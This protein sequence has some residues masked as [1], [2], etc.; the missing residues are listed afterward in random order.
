MADA[1][2]GPHRER[3]FYGRR[4][5]HALS[6]AQEERLERVLPRTRLDL[7]PALARLTDLFRKGTDDVW[8][9]IGFGG[10]EHLAAQ[11]AAHPGIGFIG[12]EPFLNGISQLAGA[13]ESRALDNV[14]MH[15]DEVQPLLEWLPEASIGRVFIL[16]PDPWPKRRHWKRRLVSPTTLRALV[17]VMRPGAEL[18][19]ATDIGNYVRTTLLAVLA[20]PELTWLAE[21][22][23]DWRIRPADWPPTRYEA[24]ALAAGRSC[25]Y[26]RFRRS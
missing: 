19:I 12:A 8:L 14:R 9:E 13:I 22:P 24:K 4:K 1:K 15:D 26:L 6:V 3:H 16:F 10:G 23:S 25:T 18:R 17:R 11:A 5:G 7:A 21:A 20:T 2:A